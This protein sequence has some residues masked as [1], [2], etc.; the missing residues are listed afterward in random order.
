MAEYSDG[1][2]VSVVTLQ[3][4]HVWHHRR[5][6]GAGRV[7]KDEDKRLARSTQAIEG[8]HFPGEAAAGEGRSLCTDGQPCRLLCLLFQPNPCF[9]QAA[10]YALNAQ[11]EASVLTQR[12]QQQPALCHQQRSHDHPCQELKTLSQGERP[13]P[14]AR[15]QT[16]AAASKDHKKA[17]DQRQQDS[18]H[19]RRRPSGGRGELTEAMASWRAPL[20]QVGADASDKGDEEQESHERS[21]PG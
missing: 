7:G 14:A 5:A 8:D 1:Q 6:R 3:A 9:S 16:G 10:L 19:E 18:A 17:R 15:A 13:K 12:L 4:S 11:Q 21:P 20:D 2:L